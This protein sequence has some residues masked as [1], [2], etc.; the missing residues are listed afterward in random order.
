MHTPDHA[1]FEI[2][3]AK[4]RLRDGLVFTLRETGGEP[5]AI[6]EDELRGRFYRVG[7]AEYTFLSLLDGRTTIG[8]ALGATALRLKDRALTEDEAASLCRWLIDS[9]LALIGHESVTAMEQERAKRSQLALTRWMNPLMLRM[10]LFSP[11]RM[12][13]AMLPLFDWLISGTGAMLWCLL[14]GYALVRFIPDAGDLW[15]GVRPLLDADN[16]W[17]L[18]ATWLLMKLVHESA[19][20]LTCQKFGGV[21]RECGVN[22][23]L[24]VPLPYVDVTSCWR[25]ASTSQRLL[26]SAAGMLAEIALAAAAA[27]VWTLTDNPIVRQ[28]AT[29]VII[30]AT[31]TTLLFNANPLM[32]SDGYYLLSDLL[33]CPNLSMQGQTFVQNLWRMVFLGLRPRPIDVS[34]GRLFVIAVYGVLSSVWSVLVG[35][36]MIIGAANLWPGIGLLLAVVLVTLWYLWPAA[37]ALRF[38]VLGNE[39]EQ[40]RRLRCLVVTAACLAALIVSAKRLPAPSVISAPAV[41][42]TRP[43]SIVHSLATGRVVR[44]TVETGDLVSSGD[45]LLQLENPDLVVDL[46]QLRFDVTTST[47]REIRQL[48]QGEVAAAE[49]ERSNRTAMT[50]REKELVRMIEG[51]TVKAPMAGRVVTRD[52]GQLLG[53]DLPQGTEL[54]T[55]A[56]TARPQLIALVPQSE[57]ESLRGREGQAVRGWLWGHERWLGGEIEHVEP[58]ATQVA[59]H[60]ALTAEAGGP[61]AVVARDPRDEAGTELAS[62]QWL[63]TEPQLEVVINLD[64]TSERLALGETGIVRLP[65]RSGSLWGYVRQKIENWWS[66]RWTTTHG[67]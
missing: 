65:I 6:I 56:S 27:I 14:C 9:G 28:H 64:A 22:W 1:T 55:I 61:L 11:E 18:A 24:F 31:I 67:V 54:L 33:D 29:N 57:A 41:V 13:R 23:L 47:Q 37:R 32:R 35:L 45:L 43:L 51:L 16:R 38:F 8:E 46:Q 40:P 20:G 52:L 58:R 34:L 7:M 36:G 3:G 62:S 59:A 66:V 2:A 53:R 26:V 5:G 17:K 49:V 15:Q 10:P 19:H 30:S 4:P 63:M 42:Q 44:V 60:P 21:V 39:T 48:N 12:L 25:L 50:R